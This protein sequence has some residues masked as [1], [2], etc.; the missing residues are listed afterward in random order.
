[1]CMSRVLEV[2]TMH[3]SVATSLSAARDGPML[4][5]AENLVLF[6]SRLSTYTLTLLLLA[7]GREGP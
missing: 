2:E 4:L 3:V 1:M 5:D 7:G 6:S